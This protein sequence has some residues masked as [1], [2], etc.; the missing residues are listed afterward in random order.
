MSKA[1]SDFLCLQELHRRIKDDPVNAGWYM[2][3]A[4]KLGA[5]CT[6][7]EA[8]ELAPAKEKPKLSVVKP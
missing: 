7:D 1:D 4:Y 8:L 5:G 6:A 2:H 3:R